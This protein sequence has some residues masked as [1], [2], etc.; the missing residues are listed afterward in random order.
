MLTG[1]SSTILGDS[2]G[3]GRRRRL[4]CGG[5]LRPEGFDEVPAQLVPVPARERS[6]EVRPRVALRG[7]V[8]SLRA[9]AANPV[10]GG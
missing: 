4:L 6:A 2:G 9:G 5:H 10:Y 1:T 3:P 7:R 8:R